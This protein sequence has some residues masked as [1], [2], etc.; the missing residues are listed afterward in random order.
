MHRANLHTPDLTPAHLFGMLVPS[1]VS[2]NVLGLEPSGQPRWRAVS[3]R[4]S[5][6]PW[7]WMATENALHTSGAPPPHLRRE[8]SHGILVFSMVISA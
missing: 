1:V 7:C 8:T 2:T 3:V 5:E 6:V 4:H